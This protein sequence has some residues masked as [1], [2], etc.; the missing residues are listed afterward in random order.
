MV[1]LFVRS[2]ACVLLI[3]TLCAFC[4]WRNDAIPDLSQITALLQ[5]TADRLDDLTSLVQGGQIGAPP[6]DQNS[7]YDYVPD[8]AL[9]AELEGYIVSAMLAH[10]AEIDL[11]S[12]HIRQ[13][14]VQG[15]FAAIRYSHPELFF[16]GNEKNMIGSLGDEVRTFQPE[17]LYDAATVASMMVTYEA[18]ID[19]ICAGAPA[20]GEFDKW[21]YLHDYFVKNYQYDNTYTIRDAYTL[22]TAKT[23]V[24][25]AYMLGFIAAAQELGLE[26]IPVTSN[27]MKHAWN[28]VKLDGEW[29][30]VDVTWDDTVSYATYTSYAHFLRSDTSFYHMA[31]PHHDWSTTER[32]TSTRFDSAAWHDSLTPMVQH[33]NLYYVTVPTQ[34]SGND[35]VMGKV[36]RGMDPAAMTECF[37]INA[38]W[39]A[40][41]S[42]SYYVGCYTGLAVYGDWLIY[43]TN[44]TLRA[45]HTK[46]AEH[47]LLCMLSLPNG[48]NIYGIVQ[49]EGTTL[50]YLTANHPQ[51]DDTV[52]YYSY[53]LA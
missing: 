13:G 25:Q 33:D 32:A 53:L 14:E 10:E 30:H 43:N 21:L 26:T 4:L 42:G 16:W 6:V 20:T 40:D 22:F 51:S 8:G 45:Y 38:I 47:R 36:Y 48:E 7:S 50:I 18:Q 2:V 28:L 23:G 9:D 35:R 37:A 49:I 31:V 39:P 44:N 5:G 29:Y 24:C 34:N 46:T 19:A 12:Y 3:T 11:S 41:S 1:K 15:I 27:A 17:Y 52:S